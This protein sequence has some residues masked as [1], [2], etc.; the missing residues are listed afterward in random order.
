MVV[1]ERREHA[2]VLESQFV[3]FRREGASTSRLAT[4]GDLSE[5]GIFIRTTALLR[6]GTELEVDFNAQ[7]GGNAYLVR[8]HA[9]VAWVARDERSTNMGPGFGVRFVDPPEDVVGLLK[10][11]VHNRDGEAKKPAKG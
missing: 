5:G 4:I 9:E 2:R 11:I 1:A 10:N 6:S 7:Y 3:R 8:C